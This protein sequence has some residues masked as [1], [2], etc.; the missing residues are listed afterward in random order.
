VILYRRALRGPSMSKRDTISTRGRVNPTPSA[1]RKSRVN[2]TSKSP[3]SLRDRSR[4]FAKVDLSG[5]VDECRI[6]T[7]GTN[8]S[9]Y[10]TFWFRGKMEKAHRVAW[11]LKHGSI[12]TIEG[13]PQV[14]VLHKCDTPRCVNPRHLFLGTQQDN[15]RD[16]VQK[17]R[18]KRNS[19][20]VTLQSRV[21]PTSL[22]PV[23]DFDFGPP[24]VATVICRNCNRAIGPDEPFRTIAPSKVRFHVGCLSRRP[25]WIH[26]QYDQ[27][28]RPIVLTV[29]LTES[30][31]RVYLSDLVEAKA[32]RTP[33]TCK[34]G[35]DWKEHSLVTGTCNAEVEQEVF[36]GPS[37]S[38]TK[39]WD[40]LA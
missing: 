6:W 33:G 4:F 30:A 25:A 10:G 14:L 15:M 32:G 28:G 22:T 34:C 8:P 40:A 35:H 21:D 26:A 24:E 3:P 37:C 31:L 27:Y 16:M 13:W 19:P 7:A 20:Y 29:P 23:L 11:I 1:R 39:Y 12:P 18:S 9:G 5:G 17:G 2:P 38:C 36:P